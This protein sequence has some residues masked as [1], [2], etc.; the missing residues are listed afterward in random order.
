MMPKPHS[1]KE[2][3]KCLNMIKQNTYCQMA[4]HLINTNLR[5]H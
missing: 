2:T 4:F 5:Y 1:K 3:Y